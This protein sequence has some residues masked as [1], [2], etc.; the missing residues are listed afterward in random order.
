MSPFYRLAPFIQE[1]I[2][3]SN[4]DEL[5]DV[6]VQAISQIMDHAGHVLIAAGTASGKT[7]AA[8]FPILSMLAEKK[9]SSFGVLYIGPLKAL[10]N[11]QFSR[12]QGLLE[13][14]DFP[15]YAWH[16]DRSQTEKAR[17]VRNP[18]GVLQIT[19]EALEGLLM[20]RSGDAARMFSALEFIV[21]DELHA[22][23]GTDRGLQLQCQ[24]VRLDRLVGHSIRRIGLSATISDYEAAT[25]W[26][27][28]GSRLTAS[29][30]ESHAAG[31][32]LNLAMA[33]FAYRD[34]PESKLAATRK[35]HEYL[36]QQAQGR[37]SIIFT[38]SR[39]AS[40]EVGTALTEI[41]ERRREPECF[42]VHHGSIA[43]A[44]REEAEAA[45]R[46]REKSAVAI[47][48]KTLEL[49]IDLGSL[50]RV[51]Q[52][53]APNRCA[54][55][56]QRLGRTG[57]RGTPAVMRFA[58]M[59]QIA[60]H[61]DFESIPWELL[62]N[63][64]IV[65]LYLEER[66]VEP[67]DSKA[68]PY[69]VLFHQLLSALMQKEQTGRELAR[70][71]LTLPA[72][73]QIPQGDCLTLLKHML[74]T[75]MIEQTESGMLIPGLKGA[76]IAEHYTF[77][78]VFAENEG[79]RVISKQREIGEV[80]RCPEMDEVIALAGRSWIVTEL[81]EQRRVIYVLPAKQSAKTK[82]ISSGGGIHDRIAMRMRDILL[83][84]A[85]YPYLLPEAADAL[86][87]A[88]EWGR[89]YNLQG[90]CTQL[91]GK[92]LLLH[93]W[94][95]ARKMDTLFFLLKK[96]LGEELQ[97]QDVV[98]IR[99]G[100][101]IYVTTELP[102]DAFMKK[103]RALLH[104]LAEEKLISQAQPTCIDRYDP[105]VPEALRRQANVLNRLDVAG[106]RAWAKDG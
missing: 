98:W 46:D 102:A 16:G 50:E 61:P 55:F 97:I 44:L 70:N 37:K 17:A 25:K 96:E 7:E 74:Q 99:G 22:F 89:A 34:D 87:Q 67:V 21:I 94:L 56:V 80:D 85:D 9:P 103:L 105:Y 30:I 47:A 11:D 106:V 33:H 4:W 42:H 41:A 5:R 38:K 64:A 39:G 8:F 27:E 51:V 66:W 48:T 23:M 43:K 28:A 104:D 86:R 84:D 2:Y 59:H 69:S 26:L 79:W 60:E 31:R 20:K 13:E 71:V 91:G 63:I 65:Q 95:G 93:P 72:F 32:K 101:G 100:M 82:W 35:C 68:R 29:V 10:I 81:D 92:L 12:I 1:Y 58:T 14:A 88:R 52:L 15:I 53:G 18:R 73:A 19:P 57:R 45:L 83:E 54:S 62:Q 24:L 49:G 76:R 75:D 90:S 40:E 6:Q 77:L 78:S 36:Y 3:R